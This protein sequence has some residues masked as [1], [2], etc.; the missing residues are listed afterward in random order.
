ML[1]LKSEHGA[2][3]VRTWCEECAEFHSIFFVFFLGVPL[4]LESQWGSICVP[5]E[6]DALGE[7]D[8]SV[9]F[10]LVLAVG[11]QTWNL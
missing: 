3:M 10:W 4:H 6:I 7:V 2:N 8:F 11:K 9:S 5:V 1:K